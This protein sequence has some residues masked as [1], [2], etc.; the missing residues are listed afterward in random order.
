VTGDRVLVVTVRDLVTQQVLVQGQ[1]V[2][3]LV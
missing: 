1:A 3:K 2:A